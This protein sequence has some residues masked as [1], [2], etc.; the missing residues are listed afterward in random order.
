MKDMLEKPWPRAAGLY[1]PGMQSEE[2]KVRPRAKAPA[3]PRRPLAHRAR[4]GYYGLIVLLLLL[5]SSCQRKL[6]Q[7]NGRYYSAR[8]MVRLKRGERVARPRRGQDQN[9]HRKPQRRQPHQNR[10]QAAGPRQQR[11]RRGG[12]GH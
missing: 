9:A 8:D 5:A 4:T 11:H 3:A 1:L 10:H 6:N 12:R 7:R 2:T